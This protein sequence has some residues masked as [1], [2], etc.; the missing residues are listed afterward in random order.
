MYKLNLYKLVLQNFTAGSLLGC[1][2]FILGVIIIIEESTGN[3]KLLAAGLL[4]KFQERI[5]VT[6]MQ[7]HF[8]DIILFSARA[9]L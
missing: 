7:S 2:V 8:L 5:V 1:V 4:I 3:D 6:M 9:D